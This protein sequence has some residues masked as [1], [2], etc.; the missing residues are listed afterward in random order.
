MI[1]QGR[2][3][4]YPQAKRRIETALAEKVADS[5]RFGWWPPAAVMA[6]AP[7][8]AGISGKKKGLETIQTLVIGGAEEDR[9][10]DL[11]IANATLSQLSYSPTREAKFSGLAGTQASIALWALPC[12]R[13]C[14]IVA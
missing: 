10:P 1:L 7:R 13:P 11:R 6:A 8:H 9:T 2:I 12:S 3:C 14:T 4:A 5:G